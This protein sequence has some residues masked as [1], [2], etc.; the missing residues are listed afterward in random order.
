MPRQEQTC[1]APIGLPHMKNREPG[2]IPPWEAEWTL[3]G[4]IPQVTVRLRG[5]HIRHAS[6]VVGPGRRSIRITS[7]GDWQTLTLPNVHWGEVVELEI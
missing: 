6:R 4:P 7:R 5:Y 1:T 3:F 2:G